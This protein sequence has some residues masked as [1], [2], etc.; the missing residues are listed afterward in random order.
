[1]EKAAKGSGLITMKSRAELINAAFNL[2]SK[3][4]EGVT[5]S[6]TYPF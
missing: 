4:N 6:L 2:S 1:M 3:P 5:L